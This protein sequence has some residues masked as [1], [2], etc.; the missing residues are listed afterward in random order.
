MSDNIITPQIQIQINKHLNY[1]PF[2]IK[3][4]PYSTKLVIIGQTPYSKGIIQ[5]YHLIKGKLELESEYIKENPF[6]CCSFGASSFASRDLALG[7]FE[8]NFLILDLEKG[9]PNYEVKKAHKSIIYAIDAV[10]NNIKYGTEE[11]VTGSKDGCV[12]IWDLRSDKP[13]IILEP[14]GIEENCPE[15]WSVAF[16]GC[17]NRDER[18]LGIGYDN[19]DIKIYDLRMD[20]LIYGQNFKY[21]IC[22]LEFDKKT[23]PINKMIST[24]LDSKIYLFDLKNLENNN[25]LNCHKLIDEVNN[26]T[27]WGT[28]FMPQKRDIF[29]S[30]GGNGSLNLYKYKN[31]D[32]N[33]DDIDNIHN[34]K[35][36]RE[37][38]LLNSNIISKQPIIGFD[39]HKIKFGLSCLVSFDHSVKICTFNN[40]NLT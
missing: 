28:K 12:K 34:N 30:M 26:T 36:N 9:I 10:G 18:N 19:G 35:G 31:N 14:K 7:D 16:G 24:T 37:L 22:S 15:C 3:W 21:G 33:F 39:W 38:K 1:I 25:N 29:I 5:I 27:I 4:L 8:G 11:V 32:F 40:L 20:K 23:I 6:K 2:D 17:F 13:A